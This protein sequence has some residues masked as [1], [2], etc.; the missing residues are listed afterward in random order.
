MFDLLLDID[1]PEV[2]I[3]D[4]NEIRNGSFILFLFCFFI[5]SYFL[6]KRA[7]LLRMMFDE[8]FRKKDSSR[9]FSP[10]EGNT[11]GNKLL[12]CFQALVL[13]TFSLYSLI[14]IRLPELIPNLEE[15]WLFLAC[16]FVLILCFILYKYLTTQLIAYVFFEKEQ[17]KQWNSCFFSAIGLSGIVLFLPSLLMGFSESAFLICFYLAGLTLFLMAILLI[18]KTFVIFFQRKHSLLYFI[19]Y[20]C[21]QELIP[22]YLSYRG[23]IYLISLE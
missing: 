19:L 21:A 11:F 14:R 17:R 6:S 7:S 10:P 8:L 1:L 9:M 20:L 5:L 12:L 23:F 13:Y 4:L 22:L 18:F 15:Y 3:S 2:P 16:L